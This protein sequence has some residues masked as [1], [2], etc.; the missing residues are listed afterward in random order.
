MKGW[1]LREGGVLHQ[2]RKWVASL[3][4]LCGGM[5]LVALCVL[6]LSR[7]CGLS[8]IVGLLSQICTKKH[9]NKGR[10]DSS[11]KVIPTFLFCFNTELHAY[12]HACRQG[13]GGK[14]RDHLCI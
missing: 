2:C 13:R 5:A 12:M 7:L 11:T 9:A 4:G 8:G 14:S 3:H 6:V 1:C 10:D